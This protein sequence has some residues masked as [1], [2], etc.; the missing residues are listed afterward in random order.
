VVYGN[1]YEMVSQCYM[2]CV[3]E[4]T[5]IIGENLEEAV[6]ERRCGLPAKEKKLLL[7]VADDLW[8]VWFVLADD[9]K[10]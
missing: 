6:D 3:A 8:C 1:V 7:A 5:M 10:N 4:A 9:L 2:Q